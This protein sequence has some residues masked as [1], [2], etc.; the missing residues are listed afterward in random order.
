MTFRSRR[1]PP[2]FQKC[3]EEICN[4]FIVKNEL[5]KSTSCP[6][7]EAYFYGEGREKEGREREGKGREGRGEEEGKV[8]RGKRGG[9][10]FLFKFTPL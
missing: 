8:R 2:T 10:T 3:F 4:T 7:Y 6:Q 5:R 9:T 1:P